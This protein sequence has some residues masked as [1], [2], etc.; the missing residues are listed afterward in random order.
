MTS[1]APLLFAFVN[2]DAVYW[3]YGFPAACLAVVGADFVFAAGT[4]FCAKVALPHE[5][6]L[7]GALFQT[8]TQ[9]RLAHQLSYRVIDLDMAVGDFFRFNDIHH[10]V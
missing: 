10:C 4:L 7:A 9:V 6:S 5:Q 2:S 8:M 3:A 1:V